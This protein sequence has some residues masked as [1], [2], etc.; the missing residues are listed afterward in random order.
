MFLDA[1]AQT[2]VQ[3][4]NDTRVR[5][6]DEAPGQPVTVRVLWAQV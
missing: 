1:S 6:H 4:N 3:H 5:F 2:T